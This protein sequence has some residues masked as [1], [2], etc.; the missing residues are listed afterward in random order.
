MYLILYITSHLEYLVY[1][2]ALYKQ[3]KSN[4]MLILKVRKLR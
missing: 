4:T 1:N 3:G 2:R